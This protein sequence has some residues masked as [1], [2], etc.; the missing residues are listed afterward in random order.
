MKHAKKILTLTSA[1]VLT[2][3]VAIPLLTTSVDAATILESPA[4]A[5]AS[6]GDSFQ[7]YARGRGGVQTETREDFIVNYQTRMELD[8]S[9]VRQGVRVV[10]FEVHAGMFSLNG[11]VFAFS[12][13]VGFTRCSNDETV[14]STAIFG[15]RI[16]V[17]DSDSNLGGLEFVG[18]VYRTQE[19][20]P[21]LFMKGRLTLG[22]DVIV[23]AQVGRIHRI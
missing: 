19:Y 1:L 16:N 3:I 12:D 6:I 13:G 18:R 23:F 9:I 5:T 7:I 2:F 8:F 4:A 22:D 14:N 17:T 15:F 21:R 10:L 11:S 20:G